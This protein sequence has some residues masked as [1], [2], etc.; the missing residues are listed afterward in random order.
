M[1]PTPNRVQ[2]LVVALQFQPERNLIDFS[3]KTVRYTFS[4]LSGFD[5]DANS[6]T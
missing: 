6:T 3:V 1:N 4:Q 2:K 5:Y